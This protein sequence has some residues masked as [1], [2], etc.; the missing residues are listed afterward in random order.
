MQTDTEQ[1]TY[2]SDP[3]HGIGR[4]LRWG[5][6][7]SGGREHKVYT[8]EWLDEFGQTRKWVGYAKHWRGVARL[9]GADASEAAA[10][11]AALE[12]PICHGTGTVRGLYGNQ[13]PNE[14][15]V[16]GRLLGVRAGFDA[17]Y[18]ERLDSR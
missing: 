2:L 14:A 8:I 9:T 7:Q 11:F 16:R 13:C 15:C 10:A 17:S 1:G 18:E 5:F 12:C 4:V 6:E 3:E